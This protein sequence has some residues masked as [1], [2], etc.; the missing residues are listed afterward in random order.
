MSDSVDKSTSFI[1]NTVDLISSFICYLYWALFRWNKYCGSSEWIAK[2]QAEGAVNLILLGLLSP[3]L[4]KIK[5]A[6]YS[7][8]DSKEIMLFFLIYGVTSYFI[9][10]SIL[11]K[12]YIFNLGQFKKLAKPIVKRNDL[13]LLIM[14]TII[15]CAVFY[16]DGSLRSDFLAKRALLR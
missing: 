14:F 13:I 6:Y 15:L 11:S 5:Y 2:W 16:V 1:D 4:L 7:N 8:L 9:I 3:L 12:F 10:N